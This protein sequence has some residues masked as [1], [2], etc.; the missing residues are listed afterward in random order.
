MR[1]ITLQLP[2]DL[3]VESEQIAGEHNLSMEQ[4]LIECIQRGV[5]EPD[6]EIDLMIEEIIDENEELYRRLAG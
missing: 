3:A 4:W 2:D 1:Q 6:K 5:Q